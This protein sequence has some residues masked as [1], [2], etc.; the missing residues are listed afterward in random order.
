[1]AQTTKGTERTL[2]QLVADASTDLKSIIKDEIALAKVEVKADVAK[3]GKGA[4]LLAGAG[5][6]ALY[7]LGFLL[8][9]LAWGLHAA[10]LSV[11]LGMLITAGVL[12]VI[13]LI[14]ALLGISALK[15]V[16]GKP[17]RTIDNAQRTVAAVKP[18]KV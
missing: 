16:K 13:T 2:G 4:G 5:L 18:P 6:F 3:G 15:K 11:W 1:M 8:L 12:L 7:M 9:A 17:A 14:L 10:G